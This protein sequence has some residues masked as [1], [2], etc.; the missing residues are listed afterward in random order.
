MEGVTTEVLQSSSKGAALSCLKPFQQMQSKGN[1]NDSG[2]DGD[3]YG[4]GDGGEAFRPML[5]LLSAPT[6]GDSPILLIVFH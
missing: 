4:G 1:D 2:C 6:A 3:D 5:V